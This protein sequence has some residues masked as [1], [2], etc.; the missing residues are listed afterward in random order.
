MKPQ[1]QSITCSHDSEQR[2]E[3]AFFQGMFKFLDK[4]ATNKEVKQILDENYEGN[5]NLQA[6]Q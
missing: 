2:G 3:S 4:E 6:F 5:F 1:S